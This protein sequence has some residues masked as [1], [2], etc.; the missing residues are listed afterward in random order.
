MD[1][2]ALGVFLYE[3][4]TGGISEVTL[5]HHLQRVENGFQADLPAGTPARL[6]VCSSDNPAQS[7][8]I[9]GKSDRLVV[10]SSDVQTINSCVCVL[11][12][13]L[14]SAHQAFVYKCTANEPENR[15]TAE[16]ALKELE[17]I[18]EEMGILVHHSSSG[19]ASGGS[20]FTTPVHTRISSSG[21]QQTVMGDPPPPHSA[22]CSSNCSRG[23]PVRRSFVSLW[24][25][26]MGGA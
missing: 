19:S 7:I 8:I 25:Y 9:M 17:A 10:A 11:I 5:K 20:S 2:W 1:I 4:L 14:H 22:R 21:Y 6:Q 15:P 23:F 24:Q 12:L 18:M 3:I 26:R 16:E 13:A